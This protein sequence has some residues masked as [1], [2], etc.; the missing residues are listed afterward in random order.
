MINR[1]FYPCTPGQ[2]S[3][4]FYCSVKCY[5]LDGP[6]SPFR[7]SALKC[8]MRMSRNGHDVF[9]IDWPI[10]GTTLFAPPEVVSIQKRAT[11]S[12]CNH[13]CFLVRSTQSSV[14]HADKTL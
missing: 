6:F 13:Q 10:N 7:P 12:R 5:K 14:L 3:D 2:A 4:T 8:I 9:Q 11:S 1:V